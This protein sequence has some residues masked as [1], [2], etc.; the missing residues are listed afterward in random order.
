MMKEIKNLM[1]DLGGVIMEIRRADCVK[2]FTE[3]G[4]KGADE[5]FGEYRQTGPFLQLEA[6]QTTPA[7]FRQAMRQLF[8]A[9]VSD[10]EL[11]AALNK[12]LV[13]IP[14]HRLDELEE[15]KKRYKIYLLSNTNP[16][17]W[18]SKIAAE[19]RKRGHDIDHYFDGTLTSFEVKAVK[20][21]RAIFDEAARRWGIEPG[22][23]LFLDDSAANVEAARRLG[24]Q[25]TVVEPGAE[26]SELITKY[27]DK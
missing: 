2:A 23:T 1:F 7:E 14:E 26:F 12:F 3:L 8:T 19:F 16:I 20:P 24:W 22:E 10:S 27:S 21:D 6:G 18:N 13:G 17:M 5:F 9:T 11:D 25:A 4:M 15:L